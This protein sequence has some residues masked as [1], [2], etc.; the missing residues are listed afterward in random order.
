[1]K[2]KIAVMMCAAL[3]VPGV[4]VGQHH[5]PPATP[6]AEQSIAGDWVI[7]FQAGHQSVSGS[8]QLQANG[9]RLAGTI[10]TNHTGP[11]TVENGK[12]SSQKLDATL[13]F[14]KHESVVLEGESKGNGTLAGNYTTEGRTET[15]QAERKS[16]TALL[17]AMATT[18]PRHAIF[19]ADAN[20]KLELPPDGASMPMLDIGGRPVV[21]VKISGKGPFPFILDTGATQ[22]VIDPGLSEELASSGDD[23]PIKELTFGPVKATGVKALVLPVTAMFGKIDKPPRGALSAQSFPGYLLCFDYPGKKITLRKGAL[24]DSDGRTIFAY[25]A[26]DPLPVVP[27]KVGGEEVKVHLDTGAPFALALPTKYKDQLRLAA[28]AVGKGKAITHSGEFPIFKGTVDGDIEIG[29][30][31]LPSHDLVF[32]DVALHPGAAPQGQLGYA[33]LRDFVVTL[34][35]ANRRVQFARP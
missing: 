8:L 30:F 11:G 27:L 13:V 21:E 15:W 16:A 6:T 9:E 32:T 20:P 5:A 23:N 31:K 35:S 14:K 26:D 25:G 2:I 1:M 28:P 4:I 18:A 10:E 29:E 7:H 19:A 12:C 24:P 17:P 33:A 3:G 34:G 22:T